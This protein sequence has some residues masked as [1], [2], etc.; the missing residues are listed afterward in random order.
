MRRK[1]I[2]IDTSSTPWQ[3]AVTGAAKGDP[4]LEQLTSFEPDP[5]RQ[6]S[7][8][9][10]ETLGLSLEAGD[11]FAVCIPAGQALLRWL[12]F[13]FHDARKITAATPAEMTSQLPC[14]LNSHH[15]CQ[16]RINELPATE[17]TILAAAVATET[18][19]TLL[20]TFD[21]DHEPLGFIG[22]APFIFSD[23]LSGQLDDGLLISV[24]TGEICLAR[25]QEG[26][27]RDLRVRPRLAD[28]NSV[29]QI[30]FILRQGR[31]L[32][33]GSENG[34][35]V[36]LLG[37]ESNSDLAKALRTAGLEIRTPELMCGATRVTA[38]QTPV[39]TLALAAARQARTSLNFRS[40]PYALKNE[41]QAVKRRLVGA[42]ALLLAT[43]ILVSG[44]AWL[45]YS[46]RSDQ[47]DQLKQSMR[48]RYLKAFPGEKAVIDVPLQ[49]QAK[50][51]QLKKKQSRLG[52]G[53]GSALKIL[54]EVSARCP[55]Q[56]KLDIREYS[57][58]PTGLRLGGTTASFDAVT[59]IARSLKTSPLF[60]EVKI[61]DTKQKQR[62]E[63]VEFR[64][65]VSFTSGGG[66]S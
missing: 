16:V 38:A 49:I 64:L 35:S 11:R 33:S 20:D 18:I 10:R 4:R 6:L 5:S 13:P 19:E 25:C 40:G 37:E 41:W 24:T 34:H 59:Q 27:L 58:S 32:L 1:I 8:Q 54:Q 43:L 66:A 31:V 39:A 14:D 57:Y 56:F 7:E 12:S 46:Q 23:G 51:G 55:E 26:T 3:V 22:L 60:S 50:L 29:D 21:D 36:T 53:D 48:Q 47:L 52:S 17:N 63:R 62:D 42:G 44:A 45:Q 15:I 65:Q 30:D 2:A 28:Q 61:S 9:L